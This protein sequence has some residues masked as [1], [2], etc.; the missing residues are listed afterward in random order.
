MFAQHQFVAWHA[1]RFGSHDFVAQ[2]I[3][4]HAVLMNA[5]FVRESI[6]ADDCLVR[7]HAKPDVKLMFKNAAIGARLLTPP[8]NWLDQINAQKDFVL[9]VDGPEDLTNWFAQTLM[10]GQTVGLKVGTK[11]ADGTMRYC[12]MTNGGPVFVYVR[13]GKILRMTPIDLT[14]GIKCRSWDCSATTTRTPTSSRST[15]PKRR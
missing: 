4:D 1:D 7:L 5:G 6:A 2:R 15:R 10:M 9:T 13:D 14:E 12:N 11:L 3:A 8:I